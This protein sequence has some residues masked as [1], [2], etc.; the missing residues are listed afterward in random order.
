MAIILE[1]PDLSGKS[2]IGERLEDLIGVSRYHFGGPVKS[3]IEFDSRLNCAPNAF[4]YDRHPAI[5]EQ[6]YGTIG[7]RKPLMPPEELTKMLTDLDP[8]VLYC[9]PGLPFLLTQLHHL[10]SKPHKKQYHVDQVRESYTEIYHKYSE[11]MESLSRVIRVRKVNFLTVT[12]EELKGLI[13]EY[14]RR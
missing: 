4:L 13:N 6:V 5:S 10:K 7:D 2:T 9:D 1:G 12:E 3:R 14:F 8:L 11:L